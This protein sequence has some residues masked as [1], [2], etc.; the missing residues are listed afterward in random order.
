[1]RALV[2]VG[3]F[4]TRLRPLTNDIPKPVLPVGHVPMIVRLVQRLERGGVD[5]VTLAL[6][7]RPEPFRSAFPDDRCGDVKIHYAVEPE[8]LDTAGAIGFAARATGIDDTFVV[9]NGDILTDLDVGSLVDFHRAHHAEATIHLTPVEDP[10]AYGVVDVD[11]NGRV[12]RFVEK[13]A[14][15]TEPSN[16]INAGTYVLEARVLDRIEGGRKVSIE[17]E[18]F[19]AVVAAGGLFAMATDDYWIDTGRPEPYLQ[20]NLDVLNGVRKTERAESVAS[21]AQV[22][23]SASV[24]SSLIGDGASVGADSKILESVV[25]PGATVGAG[26]VVERSIVMGR[27]GDGVHAER[28]VVGAH[29]VVLD[30]ERVVDVRRPD[31][32]EES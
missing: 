28:V 22:H 6:G 12:H 10:W 30:G 19:P 8:P 31:P 4:G 9:A 3:G 17:R 14:P 29:G 16:L 11:N 26:S 21:G 27:I 18:T 25:L 2:L 23:R 7:F 15:G 24:A 32:D 13:P 1:M 5:D 20:A